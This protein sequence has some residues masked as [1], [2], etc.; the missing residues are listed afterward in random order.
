[1]EHAMSS[2]QSDKNF[3]SSVAKFYD[4]YIVP[5]IFEPCAEEITKRDMCVAAPIR[6]VYIAMIGI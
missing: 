5:L 6:S 1:M 2:P 4:E 3:V